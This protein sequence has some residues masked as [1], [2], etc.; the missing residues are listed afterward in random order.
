MYRKWVCI[1]IGAFATRADFLWATLL[2]KMKDRL[3]AIFQARLFNYW[4]GCG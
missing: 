4:L 1:G 2:K 3:S